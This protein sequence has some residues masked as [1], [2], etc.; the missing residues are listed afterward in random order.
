MVIQTAPS[1]A[2]QRSLKARQRE[3]RAELILEMAATILAEKGYHDTSMDEIALRVGIAKGTLYLQFPSKDDLVIALFERE[4]SVFQQA[5]IE[6]ATQPGSARN[7]L[8]QILRLAHAVRSQRPQLFLSLYA[9]K[10]VREGLFE[11]KLSGSE[12]MT[13]LTASIRSIL[14]EG[15]T[16]GEFTAKIPT[17]VM[18]T[19]FLGLLSTRH[20]KPLTAEDQLSVAE[21]IDY[22]G[23]IYFEGIS[24]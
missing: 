24:Q 23:Q 8:E 19:V 2:P 22:V 17:T 10:G 7:R 9:S 6:V 4:I 11:K 14:E 20:D 3:E 12:R 15:K 18:L 21:F 13:Q 16:A 1:T 5:V